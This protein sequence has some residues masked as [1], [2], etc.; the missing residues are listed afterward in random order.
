MAVLK[1][2]DPIGVGD[3][4]EAVDEYNSYLTSIDRELRHGS[5]DSLAAYLHDVSSRLMGM[6]R[7]P[8]QEQEAASA[9]F[10]WWHVQAG[11]LN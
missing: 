2:W 1:Y 8:A 4:P 6:S 9:L 10:A 11:G 7:P 3:V 5:V